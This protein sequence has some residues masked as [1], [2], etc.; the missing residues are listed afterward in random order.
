MANLSIQNEISQRTLQLTGNQKLMPEVKS[1]HQSGTQVH[2]LISVITICR[3]SE[4]TIRRCIESVLS[5]T[6]THF[7]YIIQDGVSTDRTLD[8]IREYNDP[9]IKLVSEPDSGGSHAY[10][11]A[12][13]RCTGDIIT[14]CWSDEELL[15]HAVQWGVENMA[16]HPEVAAVYGDVYSTDIQGKTD[17]NSQPASPWDL[18]KFLCWEMMTNY[19][20]SF[21]R[22]QVLRDSG[23]FEF[24]GRFIDAGRTKLED[25][26]CI[27]YDYFALP[28][29]QHPILHVPGYVGKF[30]VHGDQLSSTPKVI[31]GMIPGLIR[32]IDNICDNPLVAEE[33]RSLKP[34]AY[35]GVHLAMINTLIMNAKSYDD[36]KT[37]LRT[38]LSHEPDLVALEKVCRESC[39]HLLHIGEFAHALEFLSILEHSGLSF[40]N[41]RHIQAVAYL[42]SGFFDKAQESIRK[43]LEW[44]P[45]NPDV[46]RLDSKLRTHLAMQEAL[47]K[48][49][50]TAAPGPRKKLVSQL[51]YFTSLAENQTLKRLGQI[52]NAGVSSQSF[53][54]AAT[55]L[56][57][58]VNT[59]GFLNSVRDNL[60]EACPLIEKTVVA[61]FYLAVEQRA[62]EMAGRLAEALAEYYGD[63][64]EASG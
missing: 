53:I 44:V 37:M 46:L 52:M 12:L 38:A 63:T 42:E 13:C 26:N 27:M 16:Q 43:E 45:D 54:D 10:Y 14:L 60:P 57:K 36:A 62:G 25:A 48:E 23:F 18:P 24:T 33:I 40:P 51:L 35:A 5:Q 61:Y 47:A 11:M 50:S 7:E 1:A 17:E 3:N 32:S 21:M 49:L 9:R 56:E 64:A 55:I 4:K 31:F 58:A 34:R 29:L 59:K 8:L 2:P 39:D 15:P 19:C 41:F 22:R 30:S 6:Y 28:A 20:A